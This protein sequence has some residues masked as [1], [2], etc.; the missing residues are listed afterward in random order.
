MPIHCDHVFKTKVKF[1]ETS[2]GIYAM[3]TYIGMQSLSAIAEK[4]SNTNSNHYND[5]MTIAT[6]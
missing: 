6:N 1:I 5:K 2:M 4:T 3:Y